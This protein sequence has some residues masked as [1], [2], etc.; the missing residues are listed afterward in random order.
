MFGSGVDLQFFR[1]G[2]GTWFVES[3]IFRVVSGWLVVEVPAAF[4]GVREA[5]SSVFKSSVS[6]F[7]FV[8]SSSSVHAHVVGAWVVA[9]IVVV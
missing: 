5:S 7:S 4:A 1:L 2:V 8:I 9:G 6:S 3:R